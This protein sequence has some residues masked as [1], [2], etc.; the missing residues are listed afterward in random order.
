MRGIQMIFSVIVF[1]VVGGLSWYFMKSGQEQAKEAQKRA[2]QLAKQHTKK[3]ALL[4]KEAQPISRALEKKEHYVNCY[5]GVERSRKAAANRYFDWVKD[6]KAGP[7]GKERVV[8]GIYAISG[9]DSCKKGIEKAKSIT[10][11]FKELNALEKLMGNYVSGMEKLVKVVSKMKRYYTDEDYKD[12]GFK[13]GRE[14][15]KEYA[16][17]MTKL[18]PTTREFTKLLDRVEDELNR[19]R[20]SYFEK[21]YGKKT[22]YLMIKARMVSKQFVIAV[23]TRKGPSDIKPHLDNL[24]DVEKKLAAMLTKEAKIKEEVFHGNFS[25]VSTLKSFARGLRSLVSEGK[26]YFRSL[27]AA[28][29]DAKKMKKFFAKAF[30][31]HVGEGSKIL[32]TYNREL[33]GARLTIPW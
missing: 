28:A 22:R 6:A 1:L 14:L 24:I 8:Y 9:L 18:Y 2:E 10:V 5:N 32:K 25:A 15:H 26:R 3:H 23:N 13:K 11:E 16:E 20:A 17:L 31:R 19:E 30:R 27:K 12:D 21:K 7:T 4:P 29:P 33:A